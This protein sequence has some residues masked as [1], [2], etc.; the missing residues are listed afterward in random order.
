M[1]EQYFRDRDESE[2]AVFEQLFN[3]L[4]GVFPESLLE[5][6]PRISFI[7]LKPDA[8][9]R[10]IV[11]D[12]LELLKANSVYPVKFEAK[13]LSANDID[14]LYMFVKPRYQESWWIMDKTYKL[15][16]CCPAI[17]IGEPTVGSGKEYEHLSSRIRDLVGPTTPIMGDESNIRYRFRGAHRIF[18][19]IHGTDDPAAAVREALVFF[20]LDDVKAALEAAV[21]LRQEPS[22]A[23]SSDLSPEVGQL[24]P[25]ESIELSFERAKY[26]LKVLLL[27]RWETELASARSYLTGYPVHSKSID[28]LGLLAERFGDLLKHE[29]T[30]IGEAH[31][32]KELRVKLRNTYYF[33]LRTCSLA[34][35]TF[36]QV[37]LDF[38]RDS[39]L[40]PEVRRSVMSTLPPTGK[41]LE[42]ARAMTTSVEFKEC[43]FDTYLSWLNFLKI[44]L[45]WFDEANL[46]AAWSVVSTEFMDYELKFREEPA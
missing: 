13:T 2:K 36:K 3:K 9:L 40:A 41:C 38:S 10:G 6:L 5:A 28:R 32:P 30:L 11:P 21:K 17:V 16:P 43:N 23:G 7:M 15:A 35:D 24:V 33:Q 27:S 29:E 1:I 44:Q 4:Q 22:S 31:H 46:H 26:N 19:L 45:N 25:A 42:I 14:S 39:L 8:Y 18:N 20:D 37:V 34:Q 12:I